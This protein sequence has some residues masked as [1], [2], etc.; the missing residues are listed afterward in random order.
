M[1]YDTPLIY[2]SVTRRE[3]NSGSLFQLTSLGLQSD[4]ILI[5]L[6]D[7]RMNYDNLPNVTLGDF[8]LSRLPIAEVLFKYFSSLKF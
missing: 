1:S 5:I 4:F 3:K 8:W 6:F 2:I 7:D